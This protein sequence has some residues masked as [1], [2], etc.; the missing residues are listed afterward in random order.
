VT[1]DPAGLRPPPAAAEAAAPSGGAVRRLL[2]PCGLL[3]AVGA[4]LAYVGVVDPNVPGHY[5]GCPLR[6][7]TGLWCPG[8][9]G[10]RSAHAL[11]RGDPV[12][13][14]GA[15]ALGAVGFALFAV[16]WVAWAVRSF[17][18]RP[19][20]V[21]LRPVHLWAVGA[22]V[23]VFSIVRNLPMGGWLHP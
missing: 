21:A 2:V 18:G 19:F 12:T 22:L 13:A 4:A 17:Q 8:C 6:Q 1:P 23:T 10:L 15:N 7:Y 5:P 3:G 11:V 14:L 9:G 20:A 16:L